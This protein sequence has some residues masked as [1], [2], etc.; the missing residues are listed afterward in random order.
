M[1]EAF[2]ET[3]KSMRLESTDD[4]RRHADLVYKQAVATDAMP[5]GNQTGMTPEE[6]RVLGVWLRQNR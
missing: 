6:R 3:P 2:T 1:H 5:I 4:L